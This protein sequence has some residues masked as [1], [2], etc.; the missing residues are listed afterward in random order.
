MLM[1]K[2]DISW[3]DQARIERLVEEGKDHSKEEILQILAKAE[4]AHG[5]TPAEAAILLQTEDAE[6]WEAIF[7]TARKIKEHIYGKRIVLF[8]PLYLSNYCVNGCTY[9]GYHNGSSICRRKLTQEEIAEEVRALEEMGHKRLA[10]ET[11]ED[12][13]NCPIEYVLESIRTIYKVREGLGNIRRV[14][15]NIASTTVENFQKL[16]KVGIG[17]Y[18]LFQETYHPET[19]AQYHPKGPKH[20]FAW[21]TSAF[22]RAMT[23]GIDDVGAGVL[24]GLYDYK[25]EVIALLEHAAHLE[26]AFG[27]GPH[28]VSVP[29]LRPAESVNRSEF[30]YLVSDEAFKR[31]V[32]IIRLALPYTGMIL[33]TRESAEFRQEVIKLGIS[34]VSAG[35]CTGVGGYAEK[36]KD[37]EAKT[38]QFQVND[39]RSPDEILRQL[40]EEGYTPSFCTACYRQ[41]R[42]GDRFMALAKSGEIG[43][44]CAPNAILTFQEYL[45]DYADGETKK[46]G[47]RRIQQ[48]LSE[49]PEEIRPD[50]AW[51]L[52]RIRRGE[53]DLYY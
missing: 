37:E 36:Y 49:L 5:L 52:E 1:E 38:A 46:V 43:K 18:I 47:E 23:A 53:R 3:F 7:K 20:D 15:V 40:C 4:L 28:T 45:M 17:T 16:K 42:T 39:E 25:F 13:V 51:R 21:H 2:A 24:F 26:D 12:P 6:V 44:I 11:G 35:S 48:S 8:A 34:Q 29:R 19:Y 10:I 14:N 31:I 50:V 41:G 33:S 22:D 9:C 32:A 27:V 30:P